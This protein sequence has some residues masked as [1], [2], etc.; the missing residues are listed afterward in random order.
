MEGFI[1]NITRKEVPPTLFPLEEKLEGD[2]SSQSSR[3][4]ATNGLGG[5]QE[6]WNHPTMKAS[7][8]E[9]ERR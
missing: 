4:A 8:E 5:W 3:P 1:I 2:W 9:E 7:I 6:E